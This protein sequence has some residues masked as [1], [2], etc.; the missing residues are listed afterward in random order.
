MNSASPI[1][2][3]LS[4][5]PDYGELVILY[6]DE[7]PRRISAMQQALE[8]GDLEGLV[9]QVHQMKGAAGSYGFPELSESAANTESQ[10]TNAP[11]EASILRSVNELIGV[12]NR[13]KARE[14]S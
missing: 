8:S 4:D 11:D 1:F 6:V 13:L 3:T 7:M 5:D 2:S 12:C 14:L 9:R 10:L